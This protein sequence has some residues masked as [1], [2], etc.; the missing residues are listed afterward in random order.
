MS[1]GLPQEGD[2]KRPQADNKLNELIDH[3]VLL[4]QYEH[5]NKL[6]MEGKGIIPKATQPQK[7]RNREKGE[8][9]Q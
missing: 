2:V 4:N 3:F 5:L 6:A 7:H 9:K 8:I 1:R